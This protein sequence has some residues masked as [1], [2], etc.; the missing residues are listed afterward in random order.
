MM[1]EWANALTR[2]L[3]ERN[4]YLAVTGLYEN[5]EPIEFEQKLG[6]FLR[7]MSS[8]AQVEDVVTG[9]KHFPPSAEMAT[10]PFSTSDVLLSWYRNAKFHLDEINELVRESLYEQFAEP[11]TD[12]ARAREAYGDLLRVLQIGPSTQWVYVTTNYDTIGETALATLD[13]LPDW[14]E[15]P[16]VGGTNQ[17]RPI[18]VDGLLDV[19]PR[20]VPVLHIHGR[21]GWY[22]RV[23]V[24]GSSE[25]YSMPAATRHQRVWGTPIV[26]L[27]DPDKSYEADPI[28][29]TLWLQFLDVL[30][31]AQRVF[32][33]GHSLND[34]V[35]LEA[36]RERVQ[37]N[38]RIAVTVLSTEK[39]RDQPDTGSK[40]QE[41]KVKREFQNATVVPIRFGE[42]PV[43]EPAVQ[44]WVQTSRAL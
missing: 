10:V 21:I 33:L 32:I 40:D 39:N 8:F 15:P 16:Q 11:R 26:M 4:S 42:M 18:R 27:P 19:I 22:R 43:Y 25:A 17:E 44:K 29:N 41:E 14:G 38:E 20:S 36:I 1:G 5:M 9:S 23:D 37:P 3:V 2:K 30:D 13:L 24:D 28:I 35:L 7:Q 31:R 6:R 34:A 12:P